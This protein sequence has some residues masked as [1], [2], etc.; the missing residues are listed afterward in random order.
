MHPRMWLILPTPKV[1]KTLRR[2]GGNVTF[3]PDLKNSLKHED[4][5]KTLLACFL[6][7]STGVAMGQKSVGRVDIKG[8][9]QMDAA[10]GTDTIYSAT[11]DNPDTQLALYGVVGPP[12]GPGGYIV[13][14]NGYGDLSKAQQFL[15]DAPTLVEEVLLWV[16]AASAASGSP[17]S[18][19]AVNVYALNGPG[20]TLSSS[21]VGDYPFAPGTILGTVNLSPADADTTFEPGVGPQFTV[22]QFPSPIWVGTEF[23]AGINVGNLAPQDTIALLS[24][25]DGNVEFGEFLWEQWD[26]GRWFTMPAAGWGGGSFDV[27]ACIFVVIDNSTIGIDE[28]G[29]M[30]NMRMSFLNGNISQGTVL[31]GYD[32]VQPGRMNMI[33]HNSKGQVM[34]ER[35]LGTQGIGNYTI[36]FSTEGWASGQYYVT[37]TNNGLP[38]TKKM[39]VQ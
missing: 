6:I 9:F 18:T 3:G 12:D 2:R 25:F 34:F 33:V 26:D 8:S 17:S 29:S 4:M 32:V 37:L 5:K 14:T 30:N 31:L 39:A 13:G 23:A 35:A 22:A 20:T 1:N 7:A 27:D 19:Y 36:D 11:L 28:I 38:L 24:T 16:G 21:A 10:R 15:L